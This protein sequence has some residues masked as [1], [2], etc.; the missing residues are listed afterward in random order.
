MAS[1]Y[2]LILIR[3]VPIFLNSQSFYSEILNRRHFLNGIGLLFEPGC[4]FNK[5]RNNILAI[6]RAT[7]G[8]DFLG[9]STQFIRAAEHG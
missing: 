4:Y 1:G 5:L 9:H 6:N 2:E 7:E 8:S 3:A